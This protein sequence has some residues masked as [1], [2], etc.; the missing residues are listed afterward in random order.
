MTLR[1]WMKKNAKPKRAELQKQLIAWV[2]DTLPPAEGLA[3]LTAKDHADWL[4]AFDQAQ[5][6][7]QRAKK[8]SKAD[9]PKSS[10][11]PSEKPAT[12]RPAFVGLSELGPPDLAE[13]VPD[14]P[15]W[16]EMLRLGTKRLPDSR[17]VPQLGAMSI[18]S[19]SAKD[20]ARG[21]AGSA[22][23][24]L[25]QI[26]ERTAEAADR[27]FL[28]PLF[29]EDA[30]LRAIKFQRRRASYRAA[31]GKL[32]S[33]HASALQALIKER[34]LE[35]KPWAG[36]DPDA[37]RAEETHHEAG[38]F[39]GFFL[40]KSESEEASAAYINFTCASLN[41]YA[42]GIYDQTPQLERPGGPELPLAFAKRAYSVLSRLT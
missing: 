6:V 40:V 18:D 26:A 27:L 3:Q 19:V 5:E 11:G 33:P 7:F 23:A 31:G 41:R 17:Q 25:I 9:I 42:T 14:F 4:S 38:C 21:A 13:G 29:Q 15:Y 32:L 22:F 10:G 16:E 2:Q 35:R 28:I 20:F 39:L 1:D 24:G 8:E 34:K 36:F 30:E 37:L 12:R